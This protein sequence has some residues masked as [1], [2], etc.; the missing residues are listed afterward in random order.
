MVSV[1]VCVCT[2]VCFFW[3][4]ALGRGFVCPPQVLRGFRFKQSGESHYLSDALPVFTHVIPKRLRHSFIP[5]PLSLSRL[6]K[7]GKKSSNCNNKQAGS[8]AEGDWGIKRPFFP[9]Q[10]CRRRDALVELLHWSM[11]TNDSTRE[12]AQCWTTG[13]DRRETIKCKCLH[14]L[15]LV[16][17]WLYGPYRQSQDDCEVAKQK[18]YEVNKR[19]H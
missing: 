18:S 2:H 11:T 13:W 8:A 17:D 16:P 6:G 5:P 9:E 12:A 3:K 15:R 1:K 7:K 19:S 10:C 14:G 4:R